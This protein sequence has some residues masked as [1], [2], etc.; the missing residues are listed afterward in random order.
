M[1][2]AVHGDKRC[3]TDATYLLGDILASFATKVLPYCGLGTGILRALHAY[4][5][6]EFTDDQEGNLFRAVIEPVRSVNCLYKQPD[7]EQDFFHPTIVSGI[8]MICKV[9]VHVRDNIC[10]HE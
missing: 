7:N 1:G 6:I 9:G 3:S 4:P 8:P 10:R 2:A 5:A